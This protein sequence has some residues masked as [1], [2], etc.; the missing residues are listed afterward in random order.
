MARV[1]LTGSNGQLGREFIWCHM[2]RPWADLIATIMPQGDITDPQFLQFVRSQQPLDL[3]INCAAYTAVDQA[4]TERDMAYR[5]NADAVGRLGRVAAEMDI[6]IVHF[7]TDY[8]YHNQ[9][10]RPLQET[11]PARPKSVYGRSKLQGEKMLSNVHPYPLIFRTSWVYSQYGRNFPKTIMRLCAEKSD[12]AIVADQTGAP[13]YAR[14]LASHIWSLCAV[15]HRQSSWQSISGIYNFCNSG[16][17]SWYEVA[18]FIQQYCHL[19][20]RIKPIASSQYPAAANRPRYSVLDLSRLGSEL[21][22]HPRPWQKALADC[23]DILR[24]GNQG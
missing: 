20:C 18:T 13:T 24:D 22:I 8:V 5:V 19:T 23:L 16:M 2:Q 3:V 15:A 1:L 21:Q 4:E 12:I 9:M 7:S 14:D 10:R 11:D 17:A 6:P